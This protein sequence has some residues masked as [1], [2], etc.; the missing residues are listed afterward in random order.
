MKTD[1]KDLK[2]F[3]ETDL[4]RV[5]RKQNG[6]KTLSPEVKE[7]LKEHCLGRYYQKVVDTMEQFEVHHNVH[8]FFKKVSS[9][10]QI[11][12]NKDKS[13]FVGSFMKAM[14]LLL[15]EK[16]NDCKEC[17]VKNVYL[18]LQLFDILTANCTT[19]KYWSKIKA[20]NLKEFFDPY[21]DLE[22]NKENRAIIEESFLKYLK[23]D[24]VFNDRIDSLL[25]LFVKHEYTEKET[26]F[27]LE[28]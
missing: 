5:S 11:E 22:L 23:N 9:D 15:V 18:P 28:K 25:K 1:I 2:R 10:L 27:L 19:Q 17:P 7:I 24:K 21:K 8:L 26:L 16:V 14:A 4:K 3:E 20:D 6:V 12:N 13:N